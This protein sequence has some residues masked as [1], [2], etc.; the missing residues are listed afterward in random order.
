MSRN[1]GS[2]KMKRWLCVAE[3]CKKNKTGREVR[4]IKKCKDCIYAISFDYMNAVKEGR[5]TDQ[6]S[7][8]IR[9]KWPIT[10]R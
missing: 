1:A 8:E 9:K 4:G 10:E 3:K 2:E 5:E 6:Y 7:W